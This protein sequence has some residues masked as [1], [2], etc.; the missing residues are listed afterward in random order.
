MTVFVDVATILK[1]NK[2]LLPTYNVDFVGA[3]AG[4]FRLQE[5]F[6]ITAKDM[7]DGII[8][9]MYNTREVLVES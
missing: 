6:A 8:P 7:A 9:G 5:T 2:D 1:V 4:L 3:A